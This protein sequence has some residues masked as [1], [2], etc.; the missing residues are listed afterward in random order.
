MP[1]TREG[2][3]VQAAPE[4]LN[5][6]LGHEVSELVQIAAEASD[7]SAELKRGLSYVRKQR[8]AQKKIFLGIPTSPKNEPRNHNRPVLVGNSMGV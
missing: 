4:E 2:R 6:C 5:R 8:Q 1:V 7:L 3:H